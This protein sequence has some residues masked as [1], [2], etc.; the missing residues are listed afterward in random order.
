MS[1]CFGSPS[2]ARVCSTG[3]RPSR[4]RERENPPAGVRPR[5]ASVASPTNQHR[6]K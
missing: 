4:A 5:D 3:S 2:P 1:H 6:D